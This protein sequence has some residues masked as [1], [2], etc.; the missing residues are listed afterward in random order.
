MKQW[1]CELEALTAYL[2]SRYFR[3]TSKRDAARSSADKSMLH[4]QALL[5]RY[6]RN[7]YCAKTKIISDNIHGNIKIHPLLIRIIDTPQFQRL[8]HLKQLGIL[9]YIYPTANHSRFEHSIGCSHLAGVLMSHLCAEQPSL[10][11]TKCDELCV[12]IAGLCHDM[13]H[14]PFSHMFE[15]VID[16]LEVKCW[17]HEMATLKLFDK[18]LAESDELRAEFRAYGLFDDEEQ[19]IK[20]LVHS[21]AFKQAP[22][23]FTVDQ[24]IM[25][26]ESLKKR[27]FDKSFMFEV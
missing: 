16:I 2:N 12:R 18:M 4:L 9:H 15:E 7:P 23:H 22:A 10:G 1:P 3:N 8:R 14:G 11:I 17:K 24:K 25:C 5:A 6:A 26:I 13:G 20:D 21:E 19:L 27:G